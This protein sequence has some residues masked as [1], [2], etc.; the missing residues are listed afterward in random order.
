MSTYS[1]NEA[2]QYDRI[3]DQPVYN[4]Y[5]KKKLN[6][7]NRWFGSNSVLL[8]A[9]CGTGV[10][11]TSLAKRCKT[12]VGID[13]SPEMITR[14]LHKAR[15]FYLD[16][17]HFVVGDVAHLPF[18]DGIFDLVFSVNTF[19]HFS[20]K[21]SMLNGLA[22]K[23]RCCRQSGHMLILELNPMSLGWSK[24]LIPV[25]VRGFVYHVLFPLRQRVI[26][27]VE[28]GTQIIDVPQLLREIGRIKV[29]SLKVGG[30]IPTYCPKFLFKIFVLLERTIEV[31]PILKRYGA[32][33]LVVGEV[34]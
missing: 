1:K 19:H 4:Y 22:E 7:M 32:H 9:G 12:I 15:G 5:V 13:I 14:G 6:L 21:K 26:D 20:D 24:D 34:Q 29:V 8:D 28:E 18:Q 23:V 30:F 27:N 3:I 25:I 16:N 17:T 31:T 2:I 11:T 10:Y 33:I